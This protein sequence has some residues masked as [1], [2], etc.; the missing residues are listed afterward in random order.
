MMDRK[1]IKVPASGPYD[2]LYLVGLEDENAP[3]NLHPSFSLNARVTVI[4]ADAIIAFAH[5]CVRLGKLDKI[6]EI[7]NIFEM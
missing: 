1:F 4:V 7:K 3:G 2:N 5:E 6:K